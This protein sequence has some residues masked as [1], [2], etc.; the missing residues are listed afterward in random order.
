MASND[1]KNPLEE[2]FR[3]TL[4]LNKKYLSQSISV[5]SQISNP[6]NIRKNAFN[7]DPRV[8]G[9]ALNSFARM[10]LE[11]YNK[12]MELGLSTASEILH[13]KDDPT[14]PV[15]TPSFVLQGN[16]KPGETVT[17]TFVLE[18]TK[19]ESV[20]CG[21]INSPFVAEQA[22]GGEAN[23]SATFVPQS[24][25]QKPG[26]SHTVTIHL[27]IQEDTVPG[28]YV[29]DVRVVGFDVAYFSVILTVEPSAPKSPHA[30]PQKRSSKKS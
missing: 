6:E 22:G 20:T 18:N 19:T 30:Q 14:P 10:N 25:V 8:Y 2:L 12:M 29:S 26:E 13:A 9:R 24:F 7:L 16:G 5:L 17:L 28:A 27:Q 23:I 1:D 15:T 4:T 11:Y 21:F 3:Q